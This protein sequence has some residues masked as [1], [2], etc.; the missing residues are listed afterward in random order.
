MRIVLAGF[1]VDLDGFLEREFL[2]TPETFAAAYARISRSP[3]S[4]PQLRAIAREEINK[5]RAQNRRIIYEMGHHS[6]AEHCVF[7]FDIMGISRRAVEDLQLHRLVS[8]T[9]ASQRYIKWNPNYVVPMELKKT[10]LEKSYKETIQKQI[11]AY[12]TIA[13]KLKIFETKYA[14]PI[15]DARYVT[16]LGMATQ[17]G[18]TINARNL[19]LVIRRFAASNLLEL[20]SL[21]KRLYNLAVSVAPSVILFVEK[22]DFDIKTYPALQNYKQINRERLSNDSKCKLIDYTK[23][24]DD[25]LITALLHKVSRG[26]YQEVSKRVKKMSQAKKF[27]IIKTVFQHAQLYDAVLREFEHIY[28]TY[29]LI[30]SAACFAQLKRHRMATITTQDYNPNLGVTIPDN[31]IQAKLLDLF[32][33]IMERTEKTYDK[34]YK[35][36]PQ[37]APYI[38]TQAHRR[39]V[40]LTTNLRELYHIAR[41]R[42]DQTAQW[43]IREL[44]TDMVEQAKTK[45]PLSSLFCSGKD[46]YQ[47]IYNKYFY[48]TEAKE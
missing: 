2:L 44:V 47:E 45:L 39:R 34:I 23:N 11:Q 27:A 16:S 6:I 20:Q 17:L 14:K 4:I 38:L 19:E 28:L 46:Q 21:G 9:E 43:D 15:E 30:V 31:I 8:Y 18:M 48:K 24:G 26:S 36:M 13:E 1:N 32:S 3:K 5:A 42:M 41:L 35:K 12:Q 7:N 22:T 40:L 10:N 25:K 37:I 29:E 33:E